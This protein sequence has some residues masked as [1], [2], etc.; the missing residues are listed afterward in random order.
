M[1][2]PVGI[3]ILDGR[4]LVFEL[5]NPHYQ[6]LFPGRKLSGRK[7]LEAVP[8]IKGQP[9]WE[10]LQDVYRT[11][12]T[13]EG[14]ELL[15]PLAQDDHGPFEDRYFNFIYQARTAAENKPDGILVFAFEVTD[16][17]LSKLEL[18]KAQDNLTMAVTAAQ[19]GTFD[20]DLIKG[21]MD[22][23]TRCR[24]LFG[25]SHNDTLD[26]Q[27]DFLSGLHRDDRDRI[28]TVIKNVFIKS[29]S[30][31]HY[32][33]EYRT[34]GVE[35]HQLRWVR[36]MGKAYFDVKRRTTSLRW[37]CDGYNRAKTE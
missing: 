5:V 31:G 15:I 7:L 33:V 34:A 24:T 32:D 6:Q 18:V 1:Q 29:I 36:A 25:I 37:L 16:M 13:Y 17:V 19:L 10:V 35:D 9:I 30:N 3:C 22:W 8:E 23:D 4:D 21:T 14:N 26:Y 11:G 28:D 12:K 27:K 20:L 2:T